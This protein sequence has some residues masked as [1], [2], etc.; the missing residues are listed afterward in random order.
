MKAEQAAKEAKK[1]EDAISIA[2]EAAEAARKASE[3]AAAVAQEATSKTLVS[4][5]FSS[6]EF[7]VILLVTL[8][9]CIMAAV[10]ISL[11]LSILG[12]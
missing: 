8:L 6:R 2:R 10:S 11:G 9:A 7:Q 3:A 4:R 12:R 5:V 1:A